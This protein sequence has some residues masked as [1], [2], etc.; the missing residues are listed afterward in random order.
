MSELRLTV[1]ANCKYDDRIAVAMKDIVVDKIQLGLAR[2]A[3][4]DRIVLCVSILGLS[5]VN[6]LNLITSPSNVQG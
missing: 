2:D 6:F 1:R 3:S 4:A 5:L